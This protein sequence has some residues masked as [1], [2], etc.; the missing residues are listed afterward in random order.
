MEEQEKKIKKLI[1]K[2]NLANTSTKMRR[3]HNVRSKSI[4][5]GCSKNVLE[6]EKDKIF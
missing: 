3:K 5:F 2:E 6:K 4:F 1:N